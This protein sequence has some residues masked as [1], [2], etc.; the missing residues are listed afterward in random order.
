MVLF[1]YH[2]LVIASLY[3]NTKSSENTISQRRSNAHFLQAIGIILLFG[4]GAY[5]LLI[6]FSPILVL[7]SAVFG[8]LSLILGTKQLNRCRFLPQ[9]LIISQ[10]KLENWITRWESANGKIEKLL[11]PLEKE[12]NED[13]TETPRELNP[14]ITNYSFDRAVICDRSEIARFL[15][16][17][18]FH[19][20]NNCAV[21]SVSGYPKDIFSTVLEMLKNNPNL[22]VY[23]LHNCNP[24]GIQLNHHLATS[25]NWFKDE[26]VN[27]YDVGILPRQ[28]FNGGDFFIRKSPQS[29]KEAK[30]LPQEVKDKLLPEELEWLEKGNLIELESLSPR[31]IIQTVTQAINNSRQLEMSGEGV[32]GD[33]GEISAAESYILISSFEE[34][35]TRSS[36]FASD[37]FG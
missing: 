31:R 15:I 8:G 17:N 24:R 20:E 14:E 11:T 1:G 23:A 3:Q 9:N 22:K 13:A 16:A 30:Q 34:D 6:N 2:I 26:R 7:I 29:R 5:F 33:S 19:F 25:P 12:S 21:L 28:V 35:N 18:N 27:I 32:G 36:V 4:F 37:S 10:K